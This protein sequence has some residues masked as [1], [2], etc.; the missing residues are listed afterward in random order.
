[1]RRV[2]IVNAVRLE[3]NTGTGNTLSAIFANIPPAYRY[4]ICTDFQRKDTLEPGYCPVA[5]DFSVVRYY[6]G[7]RS[8]RKAQGDRQKS[9]SVA[10]GAVK[11]KT[12]RGK[13]REALRGVVDC[14]PL[15][16]TKLMQKEIERFSPQVVYTCGGSVTVLRT[17][18]K[19]AQRYD[20][21]IVLHMMDNWDETLYRSSIL[22]APCAAVL[23]SELKAIHKFSKANLAISQAQAEKLSSV[24]RVPY[25]SLMNIVD[26][27]IEEP[28]CYQRN[29]IVFMYAGS[30]SLNRHISLAEIA[31]VLEEELGR[32]GYEFR[33]FVPEKQNVE[34]VHRLFDNTNAVFSNYIPRDALHEAY[35]DA[36]VLVLAEA[37]DRECCSYCKY[38]LSTKIPEY[39]SMGKPILGY[40]S[41]ELYSNQYL[42]DSGAAAVAED[43]MQ[44]RKCILELCD[45]EKR[46][47]MAKN[48]LA[49][50]RLHHSRAKC[51]QVMECVLG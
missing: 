45:M 33:L 10:V 16:I 38:S 47:L 35:T 34:E 2:L 29:K 36:D 20:L 48:G 23:H 4:Q 22:S 1:M 46:L 11:S 19:I 25:K 44:L 5:K 9:I 51:Q 24:Y 41:N 15:R 14:L 12:L 21:P 27:I 40:I 37:F 30:L 3:D 13:I 39:M 50:V 43:D 17:A 6:L 18:R 42:R 49:F 7:I 32:S 31:R 26:E 28:L 8:R